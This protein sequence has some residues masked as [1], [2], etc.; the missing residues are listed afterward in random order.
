MPDPVQPVVVY[1]L[2]NKT[3]RTFETKPAPLVAT[4]FGGQRLELRHL[5]LLARTIYL[6]ADGEVVVYAEP[7]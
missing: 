5:G 7:E 4:P 2:W 3:T 6:H 1:K